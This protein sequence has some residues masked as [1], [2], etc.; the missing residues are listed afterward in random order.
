[1]RKGRLAELAM[2]TIR[3]LLEMSK[4]DLAMLVWL[5]QLDF[6]CRGIEGDRTGVL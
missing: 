6:V 1:M 2:P 4:V 3:R 5:F